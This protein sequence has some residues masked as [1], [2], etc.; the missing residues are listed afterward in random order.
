[1]KS[2][3]ADAA[4]AQYGDLAARLD[5]AANEAQSLEILLRKV[6][7]LRSAPAVQGEMVIA[8]RELARSRIAAPFAAA[9]GS[10]AHGAG[11]RGTGRG[12]A[13]AG[14]QLFSRRPGPKSWPPQTRK[15]FLRA[16]TIKTALS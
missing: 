8:A 6:A 16:L 15:C 14:R 12:A 4:N 2:R 13:R 7:A 10:R 1:M 5:A 9:A 3:E 11:R